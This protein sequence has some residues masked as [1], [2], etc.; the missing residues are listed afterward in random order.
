[1]PL[2]DYL[3]TFATTTCET[4]LRFAAFMLDFVLSIADPRRAL[5]MEGGGWTE[6][7]LW[8]GHPVDPATQQ[9][10]RHEAGVHRRSADRHI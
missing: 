4:A 5:A 7:I 6:P 3:R 1:M 9:R 8:R 2:F 10:L